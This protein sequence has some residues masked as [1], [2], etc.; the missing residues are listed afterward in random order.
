MPKIAIKYT[1][2]TVI[3]NLGFFINFNDNILTK[4]SQQNITF[5][6]PLW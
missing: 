2:S 1:E 6:G 5:L 4:K 3:C